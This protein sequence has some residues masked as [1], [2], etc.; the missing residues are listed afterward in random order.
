MCSACNNPENFM[1]SEV[2]RDNIT[3]D[4]N[5]SSSDDV[6]TSELG[7]FRVALLNGI[8]SIERCKSLCLSSLACT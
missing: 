2:E 5:M 7:N 4:V 8:I 3:D 1:W 6:V